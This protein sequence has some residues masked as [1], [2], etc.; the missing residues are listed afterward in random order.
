M[1]KFKKGD[2]VAVY[3]QTFSGK[4]I[5]EGRATIVRPTGVEFQYR[6]KFIGAKLGDPGRTGVDRFVFG[7]DC[8]ADP[9]GYIAKAQKE[10]AERNPELAAKLAGE[11]PT[12]S[13][14]I[15]TS[16]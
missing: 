2:V 1:T 7:G 14:S 16:A 10:W 15:I 3:N 13:Q 12:E 8:Q 5:I 4:P 9:E 6:V 11:P